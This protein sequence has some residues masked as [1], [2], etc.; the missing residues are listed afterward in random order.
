[1]YRVY[2]ELR[3]I[4]ENEFKFMEEMDPEDFVEQLCES[5]QLYPEQ[6]YLTGNH[7]MFE[8]NPEVYI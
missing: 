1:M 8:Y 6:D 3:V 5:M 7:L 2:E 4:E